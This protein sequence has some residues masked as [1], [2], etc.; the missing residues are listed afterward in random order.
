MPELK[1]FI[2]HYEDEQSLYRAYLS[3]VINGGLFIPTEARAEPLCTL[4]DTVQLEVSLPK[5]AEKYVLE[6][7]V[8][9]VTNTS[10]KGNKPPGIGVAFVGEKGKS[11]QQKIEKQIAA[12]MKAGQSTDWI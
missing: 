4:L 3:F 5:D 9:W 6:G 10:S 8:V 2:C 12:L 1:K 11:L 7:K